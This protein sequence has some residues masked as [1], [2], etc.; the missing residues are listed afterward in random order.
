MVHIYPFKRW[1]YATAKFNP[2]NHGNAR[3]LENFSKHSERVA[4]MW[5]EEYKLNFLALSRSIPYER[6]GFDA[7]DA[8][9]CGALKVS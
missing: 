3:Q 5:N 2:I 8:C 6:V 9:V 1:M 7:A 4:G